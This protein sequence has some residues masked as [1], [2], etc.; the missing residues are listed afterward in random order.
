MPRRPDMPST[1]PAPVEEPAPSRTASA[2][3]FF[4]A[5][6]VAVDEQNGVVTSAAAAVAALQAAQTPE[7]KLRGTADLN[8]HANSLGLTGVINAGNLPDQEYPLR[9]WRQDKLTIRMRPL[10]PA[11]SPQEVEARVLNN[12]SQ[13]GR[14][15]GDDLFRVSGFGERIGGTDTMSALF[16]PTARMIASMAGCS[17]SIRS[18]SPKTTI[19]SPRFDRLRVTIRSTDSA[20]R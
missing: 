2:G 13:S 6:G 5:K 16:E 20:G 7:Q 14:A 3:T 15:V 19:I 11:D 8:A 17:S 12:F 18:T 4:V 1:F 10:F 9:L